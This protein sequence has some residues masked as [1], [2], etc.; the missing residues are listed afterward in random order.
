MSEVGQQVKKIS[1]VAIV[2]SVLV[3]LLGFAA[4]IV[5]EI[6]GLAVTLLLGWA[7]LVAG[8]VEIVH[9]FGSRQGG[10]F[11]LHMLIGILDVVVG[12][13]LVWHPAAALVTL[14]LVLAAVFVV[15]GIS[16]LFYG[17]RLRPQPGSGWMLFDGF[18][19]LL[20]GILIWA[21]WPLS[22]VWFIGTLIGIRLVLEGTGRLFAASAVRSLAT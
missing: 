19:S 5:P 7:L 22:S 17:F 12:G 14:T 13:Y 8:I 9:A 20:L 15:D 1:T 6:A 2:L 11:F 3:I 16:T 21:H 4:I 18:V 10:S